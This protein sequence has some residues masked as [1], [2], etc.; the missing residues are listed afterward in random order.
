MI[1]SL[2]ALSE[3]ERQIANL[4]A[5]GHR[6]K[7][8]ARHLGIAEQTVKSHIKSIHVRWAV[9]NRVE[10][11]RVALGLQIPNALPPKSEPATDAAS[12]RPLVP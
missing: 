6:T 9:R 2:P 1:G 12:L 11:T 10:L 4:V 3:R 8:I 7:E 5:E